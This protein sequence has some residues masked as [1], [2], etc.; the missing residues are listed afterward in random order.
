MT[1]IS[2]PEELRSI[3]QGENERSAL[4]EETKSL[5]MLPNTGLK[6][7]NRLGHSRSRIKSRDS[8]RNEL[9]TCRICL[10]AEDFNDPNNPLITPCKCAGSM[11]NIHIDCLKQWFESKKIVRQ[12]PQITTYYWKNYEC[13]LCKHPLPSVYMS[14]KLKQPVDLLCYELPISNETIVLESVTQQRIKII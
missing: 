2:H 11:G 12:E 8:K 3:D 10:S 13:E 4:F 6:P 9:Q 7:R 1:Q 14:R 5:E